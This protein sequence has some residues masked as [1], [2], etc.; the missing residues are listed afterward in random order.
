MQNNHW[1]AKNNFDLHQSFFGNPSLALSL[2][3]FFKLFEDLYLKKKAFG[4][5]FLLV[6]WILIKVRIASIAQKIG[7]SLGEENT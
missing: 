6:S 4:D 5:A 7:R 1:T 3:A 2:F